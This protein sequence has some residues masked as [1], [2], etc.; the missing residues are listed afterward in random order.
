MKDLEPLINSTV[1][2]LLLGLAYS[3]WAVCVPVLSGVLFTEFR[4][5]GS[6]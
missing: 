2:I 5:R 4:S 1:E 6:R 3:G